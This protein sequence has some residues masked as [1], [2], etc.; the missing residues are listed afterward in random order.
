MNTVADIPDSHTLVSDGMEQSTII[1]RVGKDPDD[2][3]HG[4]IFVDI[5]NAEYR[6]VVWFPGV[7]PHLQKPVTVIR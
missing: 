2:W 4:R 1:G 7:V 3:S 6:S 5:E